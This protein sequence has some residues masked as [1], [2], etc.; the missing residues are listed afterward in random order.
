MRYKYQIRYTLEVPADRPRPRLREARAEAGLTQVRL[1]ALGGITQPEVARWEIGAVTPAVT[2][3]LR[4]A[5]ILDTTV[6]AIWG[7]DDFVAHNSFPVR[8]GAR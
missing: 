3:A 4:L 1:A 6:E 8:G 2:A 5:R 7:Q